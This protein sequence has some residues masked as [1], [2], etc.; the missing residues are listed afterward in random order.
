M[1]AC[2]QRPGAGL[3][4][5]DQHSATALAVADQF[6]GLEKDTTP[7]HVLSAMKRAAVYLGFP[8][9]VVQ[10][11]DLMFSWSMPQDWRAGHTPTVW[12]R[13]DKLSHLLGIS[14]R[15]VQKI[16]NK[17]QELGLVTFR[18]SPNGNRGGHRDRN[19][20]IVWAYGIILSPLGARYR[21]FLE[22][23]ARGAAEDK[24]IDE[25]ARRLAS[26]RRGIR[27]L[28]QTA[29]DVAYSGFRPEDE[30][31]LARMAAER[32]RGSRDIPM[33]EACVE[34]LE[35]RRRALETALQEALAAQ[36]LSPILK[37]SS[38]SDDLEDTLSTTTNQLQSATADYS[39]SLAM[40]GSGDYDIRLAQPQ[41]EVETDLEKHGINPAFIREA[42]PEL[43]QSLDYAPA[44]WGNVI[45]LAE[46][47]SGQH[48]IASSAWRDACRVMG[49]RGAAAAVIATVEKYRAGEVLQPGAYLRGM[50]KKAT[51]A[52][53]RLG[54]TMFGLK[55]Q[56]RS[57]GMRALAVGAPEGSI[58]LIANRLLRRA[59]EARRP[60]AS[61]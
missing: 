1:T 23:A 38:W 39:N 17:A 36:T 44:T 3:R 20:N 16:L 48:R 4:R 45:A 61:R 13:N 24:R 7:A 34:Q 47:L 37:E 55:D 50:T 19:G 8:N 46:R 35:E 22:V 42:A 11:I 10:V 6:S 27:S 53:L 52:E 57:D 40:K 9:R 32:I 54:K 2:A 25:L 58:G 28:A 59:T 29:L 26:A 56:A 49:Q 60:D 51:N 31:A 5:F 30:I 18:D 41:T 15:Q 43:L 14:V 21:E 12:P 33:I